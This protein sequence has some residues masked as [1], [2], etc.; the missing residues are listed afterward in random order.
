MASTRRSGAPSS[1]LRVD[2]P[3]LLRDRGRSDGQARSRHR[4]PSLRQAPK[5]LRPDSTSTTRR[6]DTRR[7]RID[8]RSRPTGPIA[9]VT[10]RNFVS[11]S[12]PTRSAIKWCARSSAHWSMSVSAKNAPDQT[13]MILQARSRDAAGQVAP[14]CGLTLWDVCY[15]VRPR[16]GPLRSPPSR[17]FARLSH[18]ASPS[19]GCR[20]GRC[21]QS[22]APG[23]PSGIA[24]VALSS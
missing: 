4:D 19:H 5:P 12:A 15:S 13:T 24:H 11:R 16:Q 18:R 20:E 14:P 21:S 22:G 17:D 6:H 3:A 9:P 8:Q 7:P 23:V 10:A 1:R 2:A